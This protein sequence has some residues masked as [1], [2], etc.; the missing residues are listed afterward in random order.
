MSDIYFYQSTVADE[1]N[2]FV[3]I[4]AADFDGDGDRDILGSASNDNQISWWEYDSSDGT[5]TEHIVTE[6]FGDV[7]DVYAQDIDGDGNVD[8]L[9]TSYNNDGIIWWSND[10]GNGTTWTEHT[11]TRLYSAS[12]VYAQDLDG[13]NNTDVLGG[14]ISS[15]YYYNNADGDG[16]SWNA[17]KI[18]SY[19]PLFGGVNLL[20]G[21]VNGDEN[22]D[23]IAVDGSS[24]NG[25]YWWESDDGDFTDSN[26][27]VIDSSARYIRAI[28]AKDIDGDGDLDVLGAAS[29]D[30]EIIWWENTAGDGSSW[31]KNIFA[32]VRWCI[33]CLCR[34]CR[35]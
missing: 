17:T 10:S 8:I 22:P 2:G 32:P 27:Q 34:R 15:I 3:D 25:I 6:D 1:L 5:W 28:D 12:S 26:Y 19:T 31:T 29:V 18:N 11:I 24:Y 20:A 13:D 9:G 21:D 7:R 16:D 35:W 4:Y 30:E 23:I 33:W 14:S